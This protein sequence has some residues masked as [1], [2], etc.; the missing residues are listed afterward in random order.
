MR[1]AGSQLW[2]S[3]MVAAIMLAAALPRAARA[4]ERLDDAEAEMK[5]AED[6]FAKRD[7]AAGIAH[8]NAA[9]MIAP[10]KPGPHLQLGLIYAAANSCRSAIANLQEYLRLKGDSATDQAKAALEDCR[11]RL[12]AAPCPDGCMVKTAAAPAASGAA[13]GAPAASGPVPRVLSRDQ[14]RQVIQRGMPRVRACPAHVPG[15]GTARLQ[16]LSTGQVSTVEVSAPFAG[17]PF[18][19]CVSDRLH[20]LVFPAFSAP[21]QWVNWPLTFR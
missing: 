2:L 19:T 15:A 3:A 17:T 10:E 7:Y 5:K 18:G 12:R 20:A 1:G 13:G 16:L 6:A 14:I 11:A 4:E 8:Y 21:E 9:R